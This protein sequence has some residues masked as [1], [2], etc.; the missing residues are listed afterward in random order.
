MNW[1]G[2]GEQL[3]KSPSDTDKGA[4]QRHIS[5]MTDAFVTA[6]LVLRGHRTLEALSR[7]AQDGELGRERWQARRVPVLQYRPSAPLSGT[8]TRD[9]HGALANAL[10]YAVRVGF[11][12]P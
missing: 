5:Q 11:H 4:G 8:Q 2:G 10:N 9:I 12:L 7:G 6:L 1:P 3:F